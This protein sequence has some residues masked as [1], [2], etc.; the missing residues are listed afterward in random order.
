MIENCFCALASKSELASCQLRKLL[1]PQAQLA[2]RRQITICL[3]IPWLFSEKYGAKET[4]ENG[5][6]AGTEDGAATGEAAAEKRGWGGG[7]IFLIKM[8]SNTPIAKK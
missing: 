8:P 4:G 2:A 1:A 3:T 7:K 6:T 5:A